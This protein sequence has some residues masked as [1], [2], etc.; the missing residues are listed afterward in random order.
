MD[1]SI[2]YMPPGPDDSK[3]AVFFIKL[4]STDGSEAYSLVDR[5]FLTTLR[6]DLTRYLKDPPHD[7]ESL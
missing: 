3:T 5:D 2:D 1:F 7:H 4:I 6:D